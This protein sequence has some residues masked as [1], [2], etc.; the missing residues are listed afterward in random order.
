L[1]PPGPPAPALP[2]LSAA[3]E[4]DP[5]DTLAARFEDPLQTELNHVLADLRKVGH[6]LA[7]TFLPE[8]LSLTSA[9]A[10]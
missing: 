5:F 10:P 1:T 2:A 7:A 3:L 9:P 6:S 8:R 4:T